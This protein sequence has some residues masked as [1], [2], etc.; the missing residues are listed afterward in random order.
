MRKGVFLV[1]GL[2]AP[3]ARTSAGACTLLVLL[4]GL[5]EDV[6][7][8]PF[9]LLDAKSAAMAGTGVATDV[10][11]AP[12][13]NPALM[14]TSDESFDWMVLF[15][16]LGSMQADPDD[17]EKKLDQYQREGFDTARREEL[18]G[19]YYSRTESRNL[20]VVVPSS[21]LSGVMYFNERTFQS[22]EVMR[23]VGGTGVDYLIQ[24]RGVIVSESGFAMARVMEEPELPLYGF[25]VGLNMKLVQVRGY[26]YN[27]D[28]L[29]TASVS[30][31][32]NQFADS[33]S[34]I[35]ADFGVARELGVWKLGLVVKDIFSFQREYGN[36]GET[37][38]FTPQVRTGVAYRSRRTLWELDMDLST[39]TAI[40]TRAETQ[41]IAMGFEYAF[42]EFLN[43]RAGYRINSVGD[44]QSTTTAGLG[45]NLGSVE[46][47]V[48]AV[49]NGDELG[50]FAQLIIKF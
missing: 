10:R 3:R 46:I 30:L 7:A 21:L 24:H 25:L 47:D 48:A 20:A 26:G 49:E 18:V 40:A 41:Y 4:M 13:Q 16:S 31:D 12:F 29:Q 1:N 28:D 35:N 43:L 27:E 23:V 38:Q 17:L 34:A 6:F 2:P 11:N 14:A 15:P 50:T 9:P 44:K 37:Y 33:S 45:L 5:A 22:A 36:S 8:F 32:E 42:F 19:D 39:N